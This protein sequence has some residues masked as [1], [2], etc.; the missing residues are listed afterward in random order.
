M[1]ALPRAALALAALL[2][3]SSAVLEVHVGTSSVFSVEG[4]QVVLPAWY[5]SRSQKKPYVTW[6]LDKEDADPFQILTY[7]DG[8]VKVEETELKPRVGFLYPVLTHNI[9]LFIN[10]TRERDSGQYM[11]TVNVVDDATGTG[12]NVGV[13][14]LTVLDPARGTLK[15]TN[16]SMEM[17]GLYVCVA[18]NRAGSAECSVALEVHSTASTKAVIAGAVLGSLGALATIVFFACQVV[19]YRRKKRDGQEEVANEIK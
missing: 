13:I 11:C 7:L 4:Q 6:L 8:V 1:G 19:G 3:V 9:S 17:S 15:L 14:N 16:L 18:E 5:T 10:A 2:G 12:K